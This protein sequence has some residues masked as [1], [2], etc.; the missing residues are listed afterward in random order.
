MEESSL[1][2]PDK[3]RI[4]VHEG[5]AGANAAM[6]AYGN[7]SDSDKRTIIVSHVQREI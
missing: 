3:T 6:P 2:V 1:P 4:G 5:L 7:T